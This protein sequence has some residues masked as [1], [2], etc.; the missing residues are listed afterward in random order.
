M[1][2]EQKTTVLDNTRIYEEKLSNI[3][4][5]DLQTEWKVQYGKKTGSL[6]AGV[7]NL[8]NRKNPVS[9][10]YDPVTKQIKYNYLL[11]LIPVVG[12]KVDF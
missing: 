10:S 9:Q 4:R 3:R 5:V 11:G 8:F 7:Q 2:P 12:Y 1:E 6:I